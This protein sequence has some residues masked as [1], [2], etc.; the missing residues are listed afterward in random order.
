MSTGKSE[1]RYGIV[2]C[3]SMGREHIENI[4]A[5]PGAQVTAIADTVES[6][7]DAALALCTTPPHVFEDHR[8]LLASGLC[9]AVVIATPNFTHIAV[10]RDAL[11]T[12]LHILIEKPVVTKMEDG[13]ELMRLAQGKKGIVWVAQEYR[14]MPPVAEMIRMAH[15][16]DVGRIQQVSIREHREPFYPKVGDWN[17]FSANTGGTLV[18]KCCHYF[19]LMDL[20]LGEKPQRVFASG[21]QRVNHLDERYEGRTPDI[22]DSAF[23]IVEY[24][25]GARAMLDLCMFAENSIDSE[26]ITV[27]GDAGKLE[28]LL[29]ALTL[30]HGKRE[31]WGTR[32]VWGEPSGSGKGVS[33][34]RVWDTNIKYA[35]QHFGAS[36][37]EHQRFAAAIRAGSAPEV[38]LEDGLRS[39]ATGLAAHRSIETGLPVL[40][41]EIL[42]VGW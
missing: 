37:I 40:L 35:G 28:S 1:I 10:M 18:E 30:R 42:P 17:R 9:D 11:A 14:Y 15:A 2:G 32:K 6:S 16:G 8:A 13:I 22:L 5:L 27:V 19:N 24:P 33:V 12:D 29:P 34:R 39:V 4:K 38:S 41:T 25:S 23:V 26:H 21:G 3:G 36:Y 7:R 20:V 31:D